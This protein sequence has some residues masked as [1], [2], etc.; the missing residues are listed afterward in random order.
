MASLDPEAE[1]LTLAGAA[2]RHPENPQG[3]GS[4]H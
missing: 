4:R 3:R 1:A 2:K